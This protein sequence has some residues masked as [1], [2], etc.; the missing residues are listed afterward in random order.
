[1]CNLEN[2]LAGVNQVNNENQLLSENSVI[3]WSTSMVNY[4]KFFMDTL[5]IKKPGSDFYYWL[6]TQ[7]GKT[8]KEA[9]EAFGK[10]VQAQAMSELLLEKRFDFV[11]DDDKNFIMAFN[12]EI[13][14]SGYSFGG[15]IGRGDYNGKFMISYAKVGV[16]SKKAIA[17]IFIRDN[18]IVL[19]LIL[20]NVDKH[21]SYIENAV[22]YIKEVFI[23]D[24]GGCVCNPPKDNCRMKKQYTI[25]G[26]SVIKCSENIFFFSQP[27]L[28]KLPD[29]MGLLAEFYNLK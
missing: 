2:V 20:S 8:L 11:S 17:R 19:K 1:M 14:K 3:D 29:Y 26:R 28:D 4:R 10:T 23:N 13:E 15:H 25:D 6:N 12:S 9:L 22:A 27:T 16:A 21:S 24:D 5:G 18:E 7:T